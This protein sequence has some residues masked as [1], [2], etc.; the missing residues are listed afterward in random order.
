MVEEIKDRE[1]LM[2]LVVDLVVEVVTCI[3]EAPMAVVV[4][5]EI[6]LDKH[7]FLGQLTM[8]LVGV[9]DPQVQ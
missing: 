5:Q 1:V 6:N 2:V 4:E 7:K 8:D 9:M 3:M